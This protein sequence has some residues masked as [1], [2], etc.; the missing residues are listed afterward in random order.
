VF[1]IKSRNVQAF[2]TDIKKKVWEIEKQEIAPNIRFFSFSS[3]E[4]ATIVTV[5]M[6]FKKHKTGIKKNI[7]CS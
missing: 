7:T 6:Y 3:L 5:Y 2:H 1:E 4:K